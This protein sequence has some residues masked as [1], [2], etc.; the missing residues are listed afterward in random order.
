MPAVA[1]AAGTRLG[2]YVL[3][4]LIGQGGMGE[5]FLAR[6]LTTGAET[7]GSTT[8]VRFTATPGASTFIDAITKNVHSVTLNGASLDP[9]VVADGI[10]IQL[11]GLA[12]E[13]ELVVVADGD[14]AFSRS[15]ERLAGTRQDGSVTSI[16]MRATL[17]WRRRAGEWRIA[18]AHRSVPMAM[19]GS[20]LA[21]THLTP[22]GVA[23]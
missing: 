14:I 11:D 17:G 5:V 19:D 12:A 23:T 18:H 13:N 7:F 6:D 9:A 22:E 16:W 20:G 1:F 8:T 21:L 2:P 4:A 10:R 15:L 3:E